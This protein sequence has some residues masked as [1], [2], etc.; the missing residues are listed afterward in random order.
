MGFHSFNSGHTHHTL[1]YSPCDSDRFYPHFTEQETEAPS[2][3]VDS[4]RSLRDVASQMGLCH[5]EPA[6]TPAPAGWA[7]PPLPLPQ[8]SF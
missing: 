4:P 1:N 6:A 2:S 5:T 3:G 7:R 8:A